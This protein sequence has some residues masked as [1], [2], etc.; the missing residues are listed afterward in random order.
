[1][2]GKI[3]ESIFDSTLCSDG[4][5]LPTYIFM[6][7]ISIADK[8]G[9]INVAPKS[10]WRRLGFREWDSKIQYTDFLKAIQ[11]LES[12]DPESNTPDHN[13]KRIIPLSE[14]DEL[15]DNRGWLIVNYKLYRQKATKMEPK[16]SSTDR[17]RRFR[18]R[19]KNQELNSD[20]TVMK[21]GETNCNGHTD[22]DTD[23]DTDINNISLFAVNEYNTICTNLSQCRK[24][25][26][27][28][29]SHLIA[30][31]KENKKHQDPE[32]WS[33]YFEYINSNKFLSGENDRKW[34]PNFDWLINESNF[35]KIVEG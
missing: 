2:Y 20:E 29:K 32:F 27:K 12:E 28:R 24:L 25:T 9:I 23:T 16:G 1:M 10:L 6:S 5:W 35:T 3:F 8:D 34:K 22:T 19:Q 21:R 26:S 17:V 33:R 30:R 31:I 7:M 14:I 13:G 4:G 15:E 11:Y 18:E